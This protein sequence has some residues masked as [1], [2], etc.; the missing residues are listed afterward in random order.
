MVEKFDR[1]F[2]D[3]KEKYNINDMYY[4]SFCNFESE[5]EFFGD[6][7]AEKFIIIDFVKFQPIYTQSYLT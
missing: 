7:G 4:G 3:F 2:S 1:Y 5:E 6:F